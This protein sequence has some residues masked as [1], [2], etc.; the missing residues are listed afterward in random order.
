[1]ETLLRI[2][3]IGQLINNSNITQ[4]NSC[5]ETKTEKDSGKPQRNNF[6]EKFDR[7]N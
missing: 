3:R 5:T 7:E 1:M 6:I 2:L 4:K